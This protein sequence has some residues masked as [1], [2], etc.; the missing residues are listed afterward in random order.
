MPEKSNKPILLDREKKRWKRFISMNQLIGLFFTLIFCGLLAS[1]FIITL[2]PGLNLGLVRSSQR[3]TPISRATTAPVATVTPITTVT[4]TITPLASPTVVMPTT[5]DKNEVIGFYVDWDL[6]SFTSLKQ[7]LNSL[8][9]LIPE[10]LHLANGNGAIQPDDLVMQQKTLDFIKSKRPSLPILAL[11]NNYNNKIQDWDRS[12]LAT[13]LSSPAAR[14]RNI[15][16]LLDFV[17]TNHLQGINIDFES[18]PPGSS[19]VLTQ[20]MSELYARFHP[21]GLEVSQSVPVDDPDFD[22]SNLAKYNDYMILMVYDEHWSTSEAGP[23]ASQQMFSNAL[24]LHLS[25]V[26]YSKYVIGIGNYGYNWIDG[27][28]QGVTI[29]VEDAIL[30]AKKYHANVAVDPLSLNPTY[31]Y[32]DETGKLHHVWFLDANTAFNQIM[33]AKRYPVRGFALWRMGSEDPAVWQIFDQ[34]KNP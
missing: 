7:N 34:Q 12:M 8:D 19:L 23:V 17:Q 3:P 27:T 5:L 1:I 26:D 31:N 14:A 20:Y 33:E 29:T 24:R 25:T 6:N 10:W 21:L 16:A 32:T 22:Y 11:V 2:G 4:A 18:V 13:M 15:Q 30:T 28:N 9:K